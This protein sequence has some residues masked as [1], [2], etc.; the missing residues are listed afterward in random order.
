MPASLRAKPDR[1]D[2]TGF[3][4]LT[5]LAEEKLGSRFRGNDETA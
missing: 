2:V 3:T 5:A 4:P 1:T